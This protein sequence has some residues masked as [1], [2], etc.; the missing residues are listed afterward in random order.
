[1]STV[2]AQPAAAGNGVECAYQS[3]TF[4][5]EGLRVNGATCQQCVSGIC[6]DRADDQCGN[7]AAATGTRTAPTNLDC[8]F[9]NDVYS[10]G[11]VHDNGGNCQRCG[12]GGSS[13]GVFVDAADSFCARSKPAGHQPAQG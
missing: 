4:P 1:M 3:N 12:A 8:V 9:G 10:N 13:P 6:L 5:D 2:A 7:P 11:A